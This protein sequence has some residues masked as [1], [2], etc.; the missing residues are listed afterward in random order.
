[1]R[2]LAFAVVASLALAPFGAR[3]Q[4]FAQQRV[5]G[6]RIT[7]LAAAQIAFVSHGAD[8]AFVPIAT[9]PDQLVGEGRVDL[10][11]GA[12]TG[13]R[14]FVNVP[15]EIDL[16][17]KLDRTVLVGYRVQQY[18]DT[19]VAARDIA[20]GEVLGQDDVTMAR[21]PFTGMPGNGMDV[22]VGRR[23]NEAVL[24]G[25]P[26]TIAATSVNQVV[27][28][29]ATVV[30]V[31]RDGG[32]AVSADVIARTGGGIG[33]QVFVYNPATHK[34]LSGT[35]TGPGTVELDISGGDNT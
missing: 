17:G 14:S 24:K 18:V 35:V 23:L 28:A 1:M 33:D 12:P 8:E 11:A 2:V 22:L 19:A 16:D 15:I 3:A 21:V 26:I 25:Q 30:L 7:M 31:I 34:A 9:V 32:V 13:S 10:H 4:G 6:K 29:G 5:S 20:P 27:K